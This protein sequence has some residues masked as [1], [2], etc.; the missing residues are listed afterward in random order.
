M[1]SLYDV[2][3]IYDERFSEAANQAYKKHYKKLFSGCGI[4]SILDCSIGTGCLTF[5]LCELG[6]EVS[7]SDISRPMLA[8]A[9]KKAAQKG[10]QIDLKHC[11]FRE[12][13]KQ[14]HTKFS[15]VMSTG[16]ALAHVNNDDVAKT[17]REMDSLVKAGGYIYFDSRNWDKELKEKQRFKPFGKPFCKMDGT[18]IHYVQVWDYHSDASITINILQAYEKENEILRQEVYEE[19]LIPFRKNQILS[20]LSQMGYQNITIKPFPYFSEIPY[21]D[22]PWYCLLAHKPMA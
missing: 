15:C 12:L 19:H 1:A 17:L 6:Y 13:S 4:S 3:D 5:C 8:Q 16:N 18:R 21:E 2:P 20:V 22:T 11:D 10:I 7:G 14:Y 9:A